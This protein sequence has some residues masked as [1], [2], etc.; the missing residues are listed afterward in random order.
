MTSQQIGLDAPRGALTG[1]VALVAGATGPVGRAIA[2]ALAGAGASVA[3]HYRSSPEVAAALAAELPTPSLA[4]GADFTDSAQVDAAYSQI[5][6]QLGPVDIL[7]NSSHISMAPTPFLETSEALLASQLDSVKGHAFLCQRAIPNMREG[8]WGRIVYLAGAL[9][10]RPH[11]GFAA[12]AAAKS[13]ATAMTKYIALEE[14][15][16]GIT[17]NIIAPG[18]VL[19]PADTE[20]LEPQWQALADKLLEGMALGVF[21]DTNDVAAIVSLLVGPGSGHLTAQTLWV[22]GGE[23]IA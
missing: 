18:R 5:E 12:Y 21:P 23:P 4:V 11:H 2:F 1:R 14:G 6:A 8:G 15:K 3:V 9:M 20:P 16:Y 13:G 7:V 19:N 22:T 17:A 10:S